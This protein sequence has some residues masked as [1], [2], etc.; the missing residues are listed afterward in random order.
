MTT[1][2]IL[3]DSLIT[4]HYR[5]TNSDG[6][7]FISTFGSGP[8]T[9]QMGTGE[10]AP[11][12]ESCLLGVSTGE[13]RIFE[14]PPDQA[15]G[16]P[17]QQLIQRLP[18]SDVPEGVNTEVLST[19]EFRNAAGQQFS[20]I[21]RERNENGVLVDFNHPLAGKVLRFEVDIKGIL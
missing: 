14:L 16:V 21:V 10:L 15:F 11:P 3:A 1:Q 2:V 4:L 17:N 18:F 19:I 13:H 12:F 6:V 9:L 7:E 8:A 5:V 20:G